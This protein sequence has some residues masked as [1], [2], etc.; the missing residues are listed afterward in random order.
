MNR[1]AYLVTCNQVL[2]AVT[3]YNTPAHI[4]HIN[5]ALGLGGADDETL[6]LRNLRSPAAREMIDQYFEDHRDVH[7]PARFLGVLTYEDAASQWRASLHD[8]SVDVN[9]PPVYIAIVSSFP[10]GDSRPPHYLVLA[11]RLHLS[12]IRAISAVENGEGEGS[13]NEGDGDGNEGDGDD[14]DGEPTN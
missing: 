11:W 14:G 13:E 5:S 8:A 7:E 4:A 10:E 2:D 9:D 1:N 6:H 12:H 3:L